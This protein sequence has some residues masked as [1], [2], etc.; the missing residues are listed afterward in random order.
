MQP[1]DLPWLPLDD[2]LAP[3]YGAYGSY[4]TEHDPD[5]VETH[6]DAPWEEIGRL[7]DRLTGP[8]S[9]VLDLGCGAGFHICALA[10]AVGHVWGFEQDPRLIEAARR[11]VETC[12]LQNVALVEG[13]NSE[14]GDFGPIP[15]G[16]IDFGMSIRGPNVTLRLPAKLRDD[17]LWLQEIYRQC[18]GLHAIFGRSRSTFLP[19][20]PG[21]PDPIVREYAGL[22]LLPVSARTFYYEQYFRDSEHLRAWLGVGGLLPSETERRL[23]TDR[24]ALELYCRY[25]DTPGG[26]RLVGTTKVFLFRRTDVPRPPAMTGTS[27]APPTNRPRGDRPRADAGSRRPGAEL[28]M[29]PLHDCA[30]GLEAWM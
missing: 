11:R 21:G 19:S 26:I 9:V 7:M 12:G 16:S 25:N 6:G 22:A 1:T 20:L 5:L 3:E 17:A 30:G 28:P 15:D 2:E 4:P 14:A 23:A 10:P 27:D 24:A 8:D 13:S 18:L 29:G